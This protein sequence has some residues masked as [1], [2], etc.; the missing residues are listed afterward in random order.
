[1]YCFGTEKAMSTG[2]GSK[3]G[4]DSR[5]DRLW[6]PLAGQDQFIPCSISSHQLGVVPPISH[7]ECQLFGPT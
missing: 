4:A 7:V 5:Q 1:M 3:Q 6:K 2:K